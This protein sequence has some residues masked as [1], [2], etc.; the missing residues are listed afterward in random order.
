ML[1]QENS[2]VRIQQEVPVPHSP[3][4]RD[5]DPSPCQ[6]PQEILV[7]IKEMAMKPRQFPVLP[8]SVEG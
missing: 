2:Y 8:F 5:Q 6:V 7:R 4:H 3:G 1:V